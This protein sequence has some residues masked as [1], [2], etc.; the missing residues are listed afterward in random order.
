MLR[1]FFFPVLTTAVLSCVYYIYI[2]IYVGQV[3]LSIFCGFFFSFFSFFFLSFFFFPPFS[4][5]CLVFLAVLFF[6]LL[7]PE[8]T[9]APRPF[10]DAA[11]TRPKRWEL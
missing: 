6:S 4:S 9:N 2:Y 1:F 10:V 7:A 8:V 5:S 11:E 3:P